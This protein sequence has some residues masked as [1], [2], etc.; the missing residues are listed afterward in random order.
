MTRGFAIAPAWILALCLANA[1]C[2]GTLE[3]PERFLGDGG[4][5]AQGQQTGD[6]GLAGEGGAADDG[7]GGGNCPDITQTVFAKTCAAAGCHNT[8]DRSQGLDLQSPNLPSRLIG[9]MAT[10]GPGLLIDP[11]NPSNSVLYKKVT[12]SPPFGARMPSG[13]AALDDATVACIL[14]WIA[15]V[16]ASAGAGSQDGGGD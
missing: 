10:E 12:A 1:G 9:V 6:G 13:G 3:D 14:A 7:G 15:Q 4:L 11:S 16:S 8:M 5:S 2:P